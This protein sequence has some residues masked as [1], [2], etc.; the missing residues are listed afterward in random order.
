MGFSGGLVV[1][2]PPAVQETWV[3]SLG[4]EDPL[5]QGMA[6][7]SGILAWRIPWMEELQEVI[8]KNN[9]DF[10]LFSW[11]L[12]RFVLKQNAFLQSCEFWLM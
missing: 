9:P 5:E 8:A 3:W 6:T 1:K 4:W 12:V 7:H 2:N 10:L 11:K